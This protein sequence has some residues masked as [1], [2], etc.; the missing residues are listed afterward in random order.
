MKAVAK[1]SSSYDTKIYT[2]LPEKLGFLELSIWIRIILKMFH[3]KRTVIRF[4][5][6]ILVIM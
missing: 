1:V 3:P 5:Y 6:P 4:L 2:S